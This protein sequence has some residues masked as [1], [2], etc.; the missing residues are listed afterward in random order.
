MKRVMVV[1]MAL[2]LASCGDSLTSEQQAEQDAVMADQVRE[3]NDAGPPIEEVVPET[4]SYPDMEANDLLGLACA[5]A[6]GTSLGVR[7][8]ARE[9]DAFMKIDGEMVRFA[10]DPGSRELPA[11]TRTLYNGREYSLRLAIEEV[12]AEGEIED[13]TYEGTMWLYDRQDRVVY[14]GTGTTN[15]GV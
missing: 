6:P 11:N 13:T 1:A 12:I 10:A 9:T 8:I 2:A 3:A 15:C 4:I 14:T 7:V 5:Y